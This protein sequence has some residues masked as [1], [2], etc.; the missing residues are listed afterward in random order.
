MSY[1]TKALHIDKDTLQEFEK[2]SWTQDYLIKQMARPIAQDPKYLLL[3]KDNEFIVIDKQGNIVL[4]KPITYIPDGGAINNNGVVAIVSGADLHVYNINGD[5]ILSRTFADNLHSLIAIG[6]RYLWIRTNTTT[7]TFYIYDLNDLSYVTFTINI[8]YPWMA[9]YSCNELGD[10][11]M[12]GYGDVNEFVHLFLADP[13]GIVKDVNTEIK[14]AIMQ[15]VNRPDNVGA[16]MLRADAND[17]YWWLV[18]HNLEYTTVWS[19]TYTVSGVKTSAIIDLNLT[20]GIIFNNNE[21]V[22]Y[23]FIFDLATMTYQQI[24][25]LDLVDIPEIAHNHSPFGDMTPDG[26]YAVIPASN[27]KIIDYE[28]L[29]VVKTI[30]KSFVNTPIRV[31]VA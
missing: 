4:R 21:S 30:P 16:L 24:D 6:N 15:V 10:E 9:G 8:S 25:T 20:K 26:K 17:R 19:R 28:S 23:K 12:G 1:T 22:I 29:A 18:N 7:T 13:T 5:E 11:L 2:N 3:L 27:I 14:G 31:L